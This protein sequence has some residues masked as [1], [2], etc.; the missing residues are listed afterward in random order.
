ME[1]E[2]AGGSRKAMAGLM[3]GERGEGENASVKAH[4]SD[5]DTGLTGPALR[6]LERVSFA[7]TYGVRRRNQAKATSL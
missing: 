1:E 7:G 4:C 6:R 3:K 5:G 2:E